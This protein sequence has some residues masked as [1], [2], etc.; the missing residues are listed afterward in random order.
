MLEKKDFLYTFLVLAL[1]FALLSLQK[2]IPVDAYPAL[3]AAKRSGKLNFD[4]AFLPVTLGLALCSALYILL[5]TKFLQIPTAVAI[6]LM[7]TTVTFVE[8]FAANSFGQIL[9]LIFGIMLFELKFDASYLFR[10]LPILPLALYSA[11]AFCERRSKLAILPVICV[12]MTAISPL[13]SLIPLTIFTAHGLTAIT[14]RKENCAVIAFLLTTFLIV[15]LTSPTVE[16]AI[17]GAFVGA[18]VA[19]LSWLFEERRKLS[20]FLILCFISVAFIGAVSSIQKTQ[21]FDAETVEALRQ[22]AKLK[23]F[24]FASVY[25]EKIEPAVYYLTGQNVSARSAF[26]FVFTEKPADFAY[27][28]LDTSIFDAPL[29]YSALA[30]LSVSFDAFGYRGIARTDGRFVAVFTSVDRMMTIDVDERGIWTSDIA[31]I[32][33]EEISVYRL[34]HLNTT[35]KKYERWIYP[36]KWRGINAFKLLEQRESWVS[37]SGRIRIYNVAT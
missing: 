6:L 37:N 20:Y 29:K 8:N 28:I 1:T 25:G 7:A 26:E 22:A 16:N 34:I 3:A 19:A 24:T 5:R 35:D 15:A 4:I 36:R 32:D 17:F 18:F 30:N 21:R 10:I 11:Y 14:D 31:R 27:I 23:N 2:G 13:I 9:E 12:L 33:G